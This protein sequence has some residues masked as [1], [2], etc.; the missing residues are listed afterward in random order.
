MLKIATL[1]VTSCLALLEPALTACGPTKRVVV[2]RQPAQTYVMNLPPGYRPLLAS[3]GEAEQERE[4]VYPDSSAVYVTD[5]AGGSTLNYANIQ[6]LGPAVVAQRFA[7]T[8]PG[9][10]PPPAPLVLQGT[11]PTG[12]CWKDLRLGKLSIGYT[13]VPTA[14]QACFDQVLASFLRK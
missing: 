5:F 2:W 3:G 7:G 14:R 6:R 4:F 11:T 13:N 1:L 9:M 10:A 12:R 8:L